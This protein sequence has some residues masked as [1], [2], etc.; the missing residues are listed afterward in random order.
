M[1]NH[2]TMASNRSSRLL[3]GMRSGDYRGSQQT[4]YFDMHAYRAR[5]LPALLQ[6]MKRICTS[7]AKWLKLAADEYLF[8]ILVD[9]AVSL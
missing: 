7:A 4:G 5:F 6:R 3:A 1:E 2:P 8:E 9:L